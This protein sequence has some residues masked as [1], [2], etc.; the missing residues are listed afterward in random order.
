MKRCY[1]DHMKKKNVRVISLSNPLSFKK[2]EVYYP[3]NTSLSK[4]LKDQIRDRFLPNTS[5]IISDRK[6]KC[7]PYYVSPEDYHKIL[8]DRNTTVTLRARASGGDGKDGLG[9][10]LSIATLGLGSFFGPSLGA[11]LGP[12]LTVAQ[13]GFLGAGVINL[14]GSLAMN[15]LVPAQPNKMTDRGQNIRESPTLS[16]TGSQNRLNPYGVVPRLFGQHKMFPVMAATPYTEIAGNEQFLRLLFDFGYGELELTDLKI[17]N[18]ALSQFEDVE[19][20]IRYG[21][22]TDDPITLYS[23]AVSQ[24]TFAIKVTNDGGAQ[25]ITSE[26]NTNSV[27]IDSTFNGLVSISD[28]G[29]YN[30]HTV[31]VKYEYRAVGAGSW[32]LH[33]S[34]QYTSNTAQSYY[35]TETIEFSSAGQYEIQITRVTQDY[36]SNLIL[37]ELFITAL[38]SVTDSPPINVTGRCLVAMRIRATDQ[39]N[40]MVDQFNAI[41]T[42]KLSKWNGSSWATPTATRNPAWAFAEVLRGSANANNV[43]DSQIN[44]DA[45]LAWANANDALAQDGQAKWT[46]D[47]IV[48]YST[49]VFELLRDIASAGRASFS[50]IDGLHTVVRDVEQTTPIQHFTPRNSWGFSS[51]KVFIKEIH[52]VRCRFINPDRDWQQDEVIAYA[53]GYDS[54]NATDFAALELWGCT[55]QNQAWREG[56]Y[57]LA[58]SQLRPEVYTLQCDVENIVCTRGD[59]VRVTH[60]VTGWGQRAARVLS[61]TL[62]GSNATHITLDEEVTME[63]GTAYNVR[64]RSDLGV[65][66]LKDIVINVGTVTELQFETPFDPAGILEV[67]DLI[68]FGATDLESVELIVNKIEPR[69]DESAVITLL[70]VGSAIHTADTGPIPAFDPKI[71]AIPPQQRTLPDPPIILQL[72]S[73]QNDMFVDADGSLKPQIII[74]IQPALNA[75]S[76][77]RGFVHLRY[78]QSNTNSPWLSEK[79]PGDETRFFVRGV[80]QGVKYDIGLRVESLNSPGS[81]SVWTNRNNYVVIGLTDPPATPSDFHINII[82]AEAHLTW[83]PNTESDLKGYIARF[84]PLTTGATYADAIDVANPIPKF[85]NSLVLPARTGTYYLKAVDTLGKKSTTA[86]EITTIF[87]SVK[88]IN[89]IETVTES[90]SFSGTKTDTKVNSSNELII[91]TFDNW[92]SFTGLMDSW[93]GLMDDN[94][95]FI[96]E[97]IAEGSYEFANSV[98]LGSVYTSRVTAIV[99]QMAIDSATLFDSIVGNIDIWEGLWDDLNSG[100]SPDVNVKLQVALTDDDPSGTPTW[101]AWQDFFVGEYKGRG[102]KFKAILTTAVSTQTPAISVLKV[103]VD[104]PDRVD[105]DEDVLSSVSGTAITFSPAFKALKKVGITAQDLQ[106]GDYFTI[107]SKSTAGFTVTFYNSSDVAV[108]RTFDWDALGYGHLVT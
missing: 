19:T 25:V 96:D 71:T 24:N 37:D 4:I 3:E 82:N 53:D 104:M 76:V 5:V 101:S 61:I 35:V 95:D 75:T 15:A 64:I 72:Y 26:P 9:I 92:D 87:D 65:S 21:T 36:D 40:G 62:S 47:A 86:A 74:D 14:F 108:A 48:D 89:L 6:M 17:G 107:T 46:F 90:P 30:N 91:N 32:T 68:M 7:K 33:D 12:S 41:A 18:T 60:D 13:Q 99:E 44:G 22:L 81:V 84:T 93:P 31:E 69:S 67:G 39:L 42:S 105:G 88:N 97:T 8:V 20:E 27:V 38:L 79:F 103:E 11:L 100:E 94:F 28:T 83:S 45:L 29:D 58:V 66:S 52:G 56:R 70:D 50:V 77:P 73:G 2:T 80:Q 51:T 49:T 43:P 54:S 55:R 63:S 85:N 78:R 102:L 98:D 23:L 16:I 59:M 1:K 10:L 57:H 34:I 106:Q